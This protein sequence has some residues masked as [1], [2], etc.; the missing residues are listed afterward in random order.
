MTDFFAEIFDDI[1]KPIAAAGQPCTTWTP[2]LH[3]G[4]G[5]VLQCDFI[6]MISPAM[7][8]K[9]ILPALQREVDYFE[10]SIYHLDGPGALRHLQTVLDMGGLNAVQW[11]CGA[12]QGSARDWIEVY[13]KIQA[14]GKA[15]EIL[16]A[17]FEEAVE[18]AKCIKPQGAWFHV[19]KSYP[20]DEVETFCKRLEAW[21]AGKAI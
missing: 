3:M 10:K 1:W 19:Y 2:S 8:A 14:A 21:A 12:G 7:F 6:C 4:R 11:V 5:T 13:R 18:V 20:P 16:C 15:M 9:I 17:N